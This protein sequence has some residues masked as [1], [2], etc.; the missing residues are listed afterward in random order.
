MPPFRSSERLGVLEV[1]EPHEVCDAR[2]KPALGKQGRELPAVVGL[3]IEQMC[4]QDPKRGAALLGIDHRAICKWSTA[5]LAR[6][7]GHKRIDLVVGSRTLV[8]QLVEAGV[9][10]FCEGLDREG[11]AKKPPEPDA[12]PQPWIERKKARRS[13][14]RSAS[15]RPAHSV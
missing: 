9:E 13:F 2:I 7:L 11:L 14:L 8:S 1:G 3:V 6:E 5:L 15:G 10:L 12:V 4:S